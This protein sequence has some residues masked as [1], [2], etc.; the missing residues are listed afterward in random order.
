MFALG[1]YL[2]WLLYFSRELHMKLRIIL[3]IFLSFA[4]FNSFAEDCGYVRP[5]ELIEI[6]NSIGLKLSVSIEKADCNQALLS[7]RIHHSE[8]NSN[9]PVYVVDNKLGAFFGS[10]AQNPTKASAKSLA[11]GVL[12]E[13]KVKKVAG[14]LMLALNVFIGYLKAIWID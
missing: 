3:G 10:R 2:N 9:Y 4:S 13:I 7:L 12:E 6:D 8:N 11:D 14:N 1:R 5:P